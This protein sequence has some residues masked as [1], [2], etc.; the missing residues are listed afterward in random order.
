MHLTI[1][2]KLLIFLIIAH[3]AFLIFIYFTTQNRL[4]RPVVA[5]TKKIKSQSTEDRAF[6]FAYGAN[7]SEKYL[8]NIRNIHALS[9]THA[10]LSGYKFTFNLKGRNFLEPGFANISASSSDAVEGVVHLV[11][12]SDL[13]KILNSEPSDYKIVEVDVMVNGKN[14]SAK[15]LM[16][17]GESSN[18][19]K[20][21]RRYLRLLTQ[22]AEDYGFSLEYVTKLKATKCVYFP[23]LSEAYGAVIYFYLINISS[24]K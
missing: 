16:Y 23:L 22:A 13:E 17:I 1:L 2:F 12:K 19:Y 20:P 15:T 24:S 18:T 9:T 6:Y 4:N 10:T 7:M 11:V 3:I 14:I 8:A 5:D 21:S